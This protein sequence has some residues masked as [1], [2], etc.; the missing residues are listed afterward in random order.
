MAKE[1]VSTYIAHRLKVREM[2]EC[3]A[4]WLCHVLKDLNK[5]FCIGPSEIKIGQPRCNSVYICFSYVPP[6]KV[7][8]LAP[9]CGAAVGYLGLNFQVWMLKEALPCVKFLNPCLRA[10]MELL[11]SH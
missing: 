1:E 9:A 6:L 7:V 3:T 8:K 11:V 4:V 10:K 2:L 5:S